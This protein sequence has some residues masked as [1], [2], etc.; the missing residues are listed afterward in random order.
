MMRLTDLPGN[1]ATAT[2]NMVDAGVRFH[3]IRIPCTSTGAGLNRMIEAK[4]HGTR[5]F[6]GQRTSAN[7][8]ELVS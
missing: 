8:V 5:V 7:L 3:T 2:Q 6:G 4:Y 1:V